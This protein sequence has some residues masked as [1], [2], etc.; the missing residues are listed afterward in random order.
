MKNTGSY[1]NN[2]EGKN[3]FEGSS[4]AMSTVQYKRVKHEICT[5][6]RCEKGET[7]AT[8]DVLHS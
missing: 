6:K 5:R 7:E 4:D 2:M 1:R 3:I 8:S